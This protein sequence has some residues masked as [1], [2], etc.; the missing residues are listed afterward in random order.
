ML[1]FSVSEGVVRMCRVL[2]AVLSSV[3]QMVNQSHSDAS[4]VSGL[5]HKCVMC[6]RLPAPTG[7]S[8]HVSNSAKLALR[9]KFILLVLSAEYRRR[10]RRWTG[11]R[12]GAGRSST[13]A[14][15]QQTNWRRHSRRR[16]ARSC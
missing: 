11:S 7:S 3:V 12:R 10:R 13:P 2:V 9:V 1:L 6:R 4:T 8:D 15:V 5:T 16:R 14:A